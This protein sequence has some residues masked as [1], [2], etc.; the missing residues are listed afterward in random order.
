[1]DTRGDFLIRVLWE[2]HTDAIID[3][4]FGDSGTDTYRKELI[5]NI[6]AHWEKENKD[7]NGNYCNE[8]QKHFSLL[9][10]LV[11]GMLSKE[12]L[13]VLAN[14]SQLIATKL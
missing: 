13:V 12:E 3:V 7:K 1:M 11:Y 9:V 14:L 4:R 6:L 10:L 2:I 5:Y 8:Q